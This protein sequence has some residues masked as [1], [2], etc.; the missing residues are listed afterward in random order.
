MK[1]N[2]GKWGLRD[3]AIEGLSNPDSDGGPGTF[4]GVYDVTDAFLNR[5]FYLTQPIELTMMINAVPGP[6]TIKRLAIMVLK[7]P[8]SDN[9]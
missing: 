1:V 3:Y 2:W 7:E 5:R 9:E 4:K 6:V 8:L